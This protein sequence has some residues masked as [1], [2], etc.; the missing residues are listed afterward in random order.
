MGLIKVR[1][2]RKHTRSGTRH[3]VSVVRLYRNGDVRKEST[4]FSRDDLPLVRLVLDHAHTWILT[5]GHTP[6]RPQGRTG[7]RRTY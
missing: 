3:I 4:R 6:G 1:I 2:W 5:K 7:R